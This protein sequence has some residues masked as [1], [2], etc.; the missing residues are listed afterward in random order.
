[1]TT[2]LVTGV[3][4]GLIA[5]TAVAVADDKPG[6]KKPAGPKPAWKGSIVVDGE[7]PVAELVKLVKVTLG[8][9]EKAALAA[10]P[11]EGRKVAVEAEL[12]VEHGFL[13]IEV[14]VVVAGR[15]KAYD[16]LVD[17]GTGKVLHVGDDDDDPA[18]GPKKGDKKGDKPRPGDKPRA[19]G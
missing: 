17:A 14:E 16:V 5:L 13:V 11:G 4:A 2:R 10:V 19:N 6:E 8:E 15:E 9:A 3:L 7:K 12:E 1:M 18:E